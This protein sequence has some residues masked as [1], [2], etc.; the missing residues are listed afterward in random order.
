MKT[1]RHVFSAGSLLPPDDARVWV[2]WC[3][4][5]GA[6]AGCEYFVVC[7]VCGRLGGLTPS[8]T[9]LDFTTYW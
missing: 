1:G 6:F 2:P 7:I 9:V 8:L 5:A 4:T 3:C